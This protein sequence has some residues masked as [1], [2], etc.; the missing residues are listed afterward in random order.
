MCYGK[1]RF[2]T[3]HKANFG[4]CVKGFIQLTSGGCMNFQ[5]PNEP[6]KKADLR[7]TVRQHSKLYHN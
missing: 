6:P 7:A 3:Y 5:E 1:R 2:N 4:Y